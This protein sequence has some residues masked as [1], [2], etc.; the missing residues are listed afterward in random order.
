MGFGVR[1]LASPHPFLGAMVGMDQKDRCSGLFQA[2]FVGYCAPRAV[3]PSLVG[4]PRMLGILAGTDLKYICSGM[5]K[6]G[7][8]LFLHLALFARGVQESWIIW[9]MACTL[10]RPLVSGSHMFVLLPEEYRFAYFRDDSRSVSSIQH[11]SWFN[12]GYMFGISLRGFS[13][14]NSRFPT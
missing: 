12:G 9:E 5:Y 6:A 13:G 11:H 7:F 8:L 3:F 4:R 14:R 2:G 1:C 10:L